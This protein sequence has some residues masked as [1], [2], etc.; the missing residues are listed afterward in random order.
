MSAYLYTFVQNAVTWVAAPLL[1]NRM[2]KRSNC[3]EWL[4]IWK[5]NR[6]IGWERIQAHRSVLFWKEALRSGVWINTTSF[7]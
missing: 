4:R 5:W 7:M 2:A 1:L 3:R 6:W